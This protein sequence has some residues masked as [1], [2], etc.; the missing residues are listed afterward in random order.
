MDSAIFLAVNT[1]LLMTTWPPSWIYQGHS[2]D[3]KQVLHPRCCRQMVA[4]QGISGQ[5]P[6]AQTDRR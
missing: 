3:T 2:R 1:L 4:W 6:V 5:A